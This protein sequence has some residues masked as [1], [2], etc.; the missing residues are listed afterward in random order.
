[1]IQFHV[2]YVVYRRKQE[3]PF[4][5]DN[6][7]NWT[8]RITAGLSDCDLN[9]LRFTRLRQKTY[10]YLVHISS[11]RHEWENGTLLKKSTPNGYYAFCLLLTCL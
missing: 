5:R 6:D 3:R 7:S 10:V 4:S 9:S 11:K 1:V 8:W 2:Y